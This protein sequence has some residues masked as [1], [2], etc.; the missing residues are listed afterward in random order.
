MGVETL[1]GSVLED[2]AY[3]VA[4]GTNPNGQARTE[5]RVTSTYRS[6]ILERGIAMAL[7]ER[8][9]ERMGD[10]LRFTRIGLDPVE[11]RI[12]SLVF[13]DP[14]GTKQDA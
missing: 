12:V 14:E 11:A 2:G 10:I 8:G 1:D 3:A 5:G 7:V 4:A 9:P 13:L 6:P